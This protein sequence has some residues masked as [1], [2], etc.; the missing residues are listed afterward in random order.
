MTEEAKLWE[1][2]LFEI[3]K[4]LSINS[5]YISNYLTKNKSTF[6]IILKNAR[7]FN[8]LENPCQTP[9]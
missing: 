7:K 6:P 9:A 1:K 8:N 4:H 5:F 2:H 3:I